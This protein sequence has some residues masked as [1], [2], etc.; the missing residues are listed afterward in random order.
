MVEVPGAYR[1]PPCSVEA[2]VPTVA[3]A[4]LIARRDVQGVRPLTLAPVPSAYG[5]TGSTPRIWGA[6]LTP[7][8]GYLEAGEPQVLVYRAP[9]GWG[10]AVPCYGGGASGNYYTLGPER[11]GQCHNLTRGEACALARRLLA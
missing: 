8:D 3:Q 4:P 11:W 6:T 2:T 10:V 5:A 7:E 9:R 1:C